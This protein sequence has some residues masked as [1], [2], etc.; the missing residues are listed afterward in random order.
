MKS[1]PDSDILIIEIQRKIGDEIM[2]QI[3]AKPGDRVLIS[4]L[5]ELEKLIYG[6]QAPALAVLVRSNAGLSQE[7]KDLKKEF[8]TTFCGGDPDP[9][10]Q[11]IEEVLEDIQLDGR[12]FPFF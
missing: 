2:A 7:L 1:L 9:S 11:K 4:Y 8:A 10:L 5:E 6:E 3:I 12:P